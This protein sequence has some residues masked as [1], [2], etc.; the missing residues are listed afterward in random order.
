MAIG[1]NGLQDSD[2]RMLAVGYSSGKVSD[3]TIF[4]Q[5]SE[6]M[7]FGKVGVIP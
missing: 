5:M 1:R 6:S 3:S 4:G 7:I 2:I